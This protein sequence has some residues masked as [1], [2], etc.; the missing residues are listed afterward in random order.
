MMMEQGQNTVATGEVST[1][2]LVTI[3]IAGPED[4]LASFFI[5]VIP[6]RG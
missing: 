4:S 2:Y 1:V 5:P 3:V 6:G